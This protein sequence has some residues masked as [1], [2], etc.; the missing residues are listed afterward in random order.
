MV[1]VIGGVIGGVIFV[2]VER[3]DVWVLLGGE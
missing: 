1:V 3:E 2:W